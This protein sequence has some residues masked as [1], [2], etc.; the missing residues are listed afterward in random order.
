MRG[1]RGWTLP[2][3]YLLLIRRGIIYGCNPSAIDAI[4][5]TSPS[6]PNPASTISL[7]QNISEPSSA[8][9]RRRAFSLYCSARDLIKGINGQ[10]NN[11]V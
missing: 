5:A 9:K 7:N 2:A 3:L 6:R 1:R 8:L 11:V 4:A 10:T